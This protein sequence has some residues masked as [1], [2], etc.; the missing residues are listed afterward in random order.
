[1]YEFGYGRR[2]VLFIAFTALA[3]QQS[4]TRSVKP[5]DDRL[6]LKSL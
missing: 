2:T 3:L 4:L 6:Y 5:I 1:M